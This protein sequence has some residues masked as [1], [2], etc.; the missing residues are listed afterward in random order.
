MLAPGATPRTPILVGRGSNETGHTR[1]VAGIQPPDIVANVGMIVRCQDVLGQVGVGVLHA[2][3]DHRY[4]DPLAHGGLP[5]LLD[6]D[7][8]HRPAGV[9]SAVVEVPLAAV[10]GVALGA[11]EG[12]A[13]L[14]VPYFLGRD[15]GM[16]DVRTGVRRIGNDLNE[17]GA[18]VQSLAHREADSLLSHGGPVVVV[19]GEHIQLVP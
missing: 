2:V 1:P 13:V 18:G 16:D 3:I 7:V 9:L 12:S 8:L 11:V 5:D 14:P 6:V 19:D 10:E 15:L 17:V 4:I